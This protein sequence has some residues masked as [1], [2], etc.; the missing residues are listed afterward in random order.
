MDNDDNN[1]DDNNNDH[2]YTI[3]SLCEPDGSGELKTKIF[4][5]TQSPMI[6]KRGMQ[7]RGFKTV[8]KVGR[9]RQLIEL[10]KLYEYSRS[11]R[12]LTLAKGYLHV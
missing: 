9:Y 6:L 2:G 11:G 1:D 3:S 10:M 12:F 5:I 7:H 4:S 8:H